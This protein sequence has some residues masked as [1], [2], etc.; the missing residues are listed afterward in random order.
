[1]SGFLSAGL[2]DAIPDSVVSRTDDDGSEQ[3]TDPRGIQIE[4]SQ[5]WPEIGGT[6][7][8][9]TSDVTTAYIHRSSDGLLMGQTDISGLVAGDSFSINL[10]NELQPDTT[11]NFELDAEG[12]EFTQGTNDSPDTPYT[13]DDGNL[14]IL[15]G[16]FD[17]T[18]STT[19]NR[20]LVTV[21]NV[22]IE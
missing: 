13:S 4:T 14:T 16:G 1:M 7:S 10:D 21:G 2:F 22:G 17:N 20:C 3:A 12:G 11:Y 18:E 8:A 15:S 19:D 6:I 5:K 9:N